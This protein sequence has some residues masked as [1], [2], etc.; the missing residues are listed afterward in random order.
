MS[1]EIT[2]QI[3]DKSTSETQGAK[4]HYYVEEPSCKV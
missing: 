2:L 4:L 3:L 1:R